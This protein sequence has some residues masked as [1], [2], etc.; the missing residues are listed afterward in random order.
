[1]EKVEEL[2]M[3][4]KSVGQI[5]QTISNENLGKRIKRY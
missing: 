4:A 1:M 3:P 2:L 5:F